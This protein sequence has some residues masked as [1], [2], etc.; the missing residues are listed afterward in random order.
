[1]TNWTEHFWLHLYSEMNNSE[2]DPVRQY[3]KYKTHMGEHNWDILDD[4]GN[5]ICRCTPVE[6]NDPD[7]I[8]IKQTIDDIG[9]N[10]VNL[11][12]VW[13]VNNPRLEE[14]Y[15]QERSAL[16][17]KSKLDTNRI[18]TK[19]L[20]HST[21][22]PVDALLAE[23][24]D[25]DKSNGGLFGYGLYA[26]PSF[27]K[28]SSY[29]S[30]SNNRRIILEVDML[31]GAKYEIEEKIVD[32]ALVEPPLGYDS[33]IGYVNATEVVVYKN[34]QAIIRFMIDY[35][36]KS[37][38]AQTLVNAIPNMRN[39]NIQQKTPK[40]DSE[41]A[42]KRIYE[43]AV[44]EAHAI[45]H[46]EKVAKMAFLE[47]QILTLKNEPLL[48]E[49][50]DEL[51]SQ[52]NN[53]GAELQS[54]EYKQKL[55]KL[56]DE[57][58]KAILTILTP[59]PPISVSVSAQPTS[60][61]LAQTLRNQQQEIEGLDPSKIL[62]KPPKFNLENF[63]RLTDIKGEDQKIKGAGNYLVDQGNYLMSYM[64]KMVRIY[65][66]LVKNK[67]EGLEPI[68]KD[69]DA[70]REEYKALAT[71]L[72]VSHRDKALILTCGEKYNRLVDSSLALL[73][74]LQQV[75]N[76]CKQKFLTMQSAQLAQLASFKPIGQNKPRSSYRPAPIPKPNLPAS[77]YL[78][79]FFVPPQNLVGST[80]SSSSATNTPSSTLS[81]SFNA[82]SLTS[83]SAMSTTPLVVSNVTRSNTASQKQDKP[84]EMIE[85]TQR[86]LVVGM[87]TLEFKIDE[88]DGLQEG[89][90]ETPEIQTI[91]QTLVEIKSEHSRLSGEL[92]NVIKSPV[93]GQLDNLRKLKASYFGLTERINKIRERLLQLQPQLQFQPQPQ[94]Q[95]QFQPQL[96]AQQF[97][98]Q[99]QLQFQPQPQMQAQQFQ[100]QQFQPQPQPQ[101]Q[102]QATFQAQE[103]LVKELRYLAEHSTEITKLLDNL[104]SSNQLVVLNQQLD[105]LLLRENLDVEI[106]RIREMLYGMQN[107]REQQYIQQCIAR[108]QDVRAALRT[109]RNQAFGMQRQQQANGSS[110]PSGMIITSTPASAGGVATPSMPMASMKITSL[111]PL[112]VNQPPRVRQ[113]RSRF[114]SKSKR[115]PK[116]EDAVSE[117]D[118]D[119]DEDDI[120]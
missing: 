39:L 76:A 86:G 78:Q 99:P 33:V 37:T 11:I 20:F 47:E 12:R 81:S 66:G 1:M 25:V 22:A 92:D 113:R 111:D 120:Q 82:S 97:Q 16:M 6:H 101:P 30:I 9:N 94:P 70:A 115:K 43:Q 19:H 98:P 53:L 31:T 34:S 51:K 29:W 55:Q 65:D 28:S 116:D 104:G 17:A 18:E 3:R 41:L 107:N 112:S 50:L 24:L 36:V 61:T 57:R 42:K 52:L 69:L 46:D 74:R 80:T 88:L 84:S 8:R 38:Y 7:Y 105:L 48:Q 26:T 54:E 27:L 119:D 4:N 72:N 44:R 102:V 114:E 109:I 87:S 40:L 90:A 60:A 71:I 67:A 89:I 118:D 83:S 2:N 108:C 100:P 35:E 79:R 49:K 10:A 95:L 13:R 96:Q 117:E 5:I 14:I 15:D 63:L 85:Q 56:V 77:A 62:P 59:L 68:L 93:D 23:G 64:S 58:A 103:Y 45:Y 32:K 91:R 21:K 106:R 110:A 73:E 75:Y